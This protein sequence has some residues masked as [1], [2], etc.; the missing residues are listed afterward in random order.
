MMLSSYFY[1]IVDSSIDTHRQ[2]KLLF[3]FLV[4]SDIV[5]VSYARKFLCLS[6]YSRYRSNLYM[7]MK[8]PR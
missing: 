3:K 5:I 7:H 1:D 4:Y 6:L 2:N 8:K